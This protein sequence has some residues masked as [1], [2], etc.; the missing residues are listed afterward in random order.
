[1][2]DPFGW[3]KY[4]G[5]G[6]P[7]PPPPEN[8]VFAT[9]AIIVAG[10]C[11]LTFMV[12]NIVANRPG[13]AEYRDRGIAIMQAELQR[14][15]PPPGIEISSVDTQ[16]APLR[17]LTLDVHY[18]SPEGGCQAMTAYYVPLMHANGWLDGDT[19]QGTT[20]S[21]QTFFKDTQGY[22]L[23]LDLDCD[24]IHGSYDLAFTNRDAFPFF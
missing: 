13:A 9:F 15:P 19:S 7:L 23:R 20:T 18:A 10:I 2:D 12:M 21:V 5:R 17:P 1:M 8:T 4:D 24:F 6:R 3:S 16:N 14:L 11:T 22:H